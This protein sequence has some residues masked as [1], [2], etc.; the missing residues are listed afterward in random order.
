MSIN[1]RGGVSEVLGERGRL[2]A[3]G[4]GHLGIMHTC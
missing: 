1:L 3:A 2:V 4:L